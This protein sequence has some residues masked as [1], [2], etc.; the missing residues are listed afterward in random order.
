MG[1][2]CE[3]GCD[4]VRHGE[5]GVP[6]DRV[7]P[8]E[9][10]TEEFGAGAV[11]GD[12]VEGLEGGEEVVE[13]GVDGVLHTEIINDEGECDGVRFVPPE[14]WSMFDGGVSVWGKVA[15]EAVLSNA[16]GLFKA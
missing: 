16:A 8:V 12:L 11:G 3:G 5:G 2:T 7:L 15:D 4:I 10:D 13:V 14:G 1:E 9:G 6:I